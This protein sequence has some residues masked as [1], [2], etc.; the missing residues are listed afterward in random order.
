[1]RAGGAKLPRPRGALLAP[2]P[3]YSS[4]R[5]CAPRLK[6]TWRAMRPQRVATMTLPPPL[7]QAVYVQSLEAPAPKT[8]IA[9]LLATWVGG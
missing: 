6:T 7:G 8:S 5:I 2:L 3:F 1:M 9:L 4:Q